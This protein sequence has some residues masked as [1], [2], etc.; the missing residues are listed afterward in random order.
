MFF[1]REEK[2]KVDIKAI[3]QYRLKQFDYMA[4]KYAT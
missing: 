2:I 3:L 1:L 4:L